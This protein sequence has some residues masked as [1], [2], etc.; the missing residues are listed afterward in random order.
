MCR[1]QALRGM[2]LGAAQC[3]EGTAGLSRGAE[4]WEVVAGVQKTKAG[5]QQAQVP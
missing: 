2:S 4:G 5:A 1:A 3:P